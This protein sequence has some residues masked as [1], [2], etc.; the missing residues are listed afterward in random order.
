VALSKEIKVKGN[1]AGNWNSHELHHHPILKT[2]T[3][4]EK[5]ESGEK[6]RK[7][8]NSL[9]S[10]VS[11]LFSERVKKIHFLHVGGEGV[12]KVGSTAT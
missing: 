3:I 12:K 2:I 5:Q 9:H 6:E 1:I 11:L 7:K 8:E 10:R 4:S